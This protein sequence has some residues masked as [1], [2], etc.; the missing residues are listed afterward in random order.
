MQVFPAPICE[1]PTLPSQMT[2]TGVSPQT[3]K[4]KPTSPN[5]PRYSPLPPNS[6]QPPLLPPTGC[7]AL[8]NITSLTVSDSDLSG[9]DHHLSRL[10]HHLSELDHHLSG[11]DHHWLH[12]LDLCPSSLVTITVGRRNTMLIHVYELGSAI[13]T[14]TKLC[15]IG[16]CIMWGIGS[17]QSNGQSEA[18]H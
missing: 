1:C 7:S 14:T 3:L 15:R 8:C 11:L 5:F 18:H 13:S 6:S 2:C 12:R 4:A 10:D 16:I 17:Y 9:L